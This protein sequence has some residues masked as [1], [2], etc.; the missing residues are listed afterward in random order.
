MAKHLDPAWAP[1]PVR[2][3]LSHHTDSE[4][5]D[6]DLG[7]S[8]RGGIYATQNISEERNGS[9]V[10]IDT[11][12]VRSGGNRSRCAGQ[13]DCLRRHSDRMQHLQ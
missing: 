10:D 1:S 2:R 13:A 11:G 3:G 5:P 12:K 6:F 7:P 4:G 8:A 9:D